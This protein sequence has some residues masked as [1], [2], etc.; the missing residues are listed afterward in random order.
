MAN[1]DEIGGDGVDD[2]IRVNFINAH[3]GAMK[4]AIA[5]G[6]NLKGFYY[7]SLL[8]NYEW[9]EGYAMRFGIVHVDYKTQIRT[10]KKS[11]LALQRMLA[12]NQK[13]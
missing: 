7:W 6:V 12:C 13:V 9:A 2:Q 8:D 1:A 3:L 11:Y 4:Q 10:P 5:E